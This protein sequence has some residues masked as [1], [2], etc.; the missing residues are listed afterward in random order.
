[1]H[2]GRGLAIAAAGGLGLAAWVGILGSPARQASPPAP[3]DRSFRVRLGVKDQGPRSW[4]GFAA[5][6]GGE[7][8]LRL[9]RP[10][11]GDSVDSRGSFTVSTRS[12]PV[13]V[14]RSWEEERLE[15]ATP[16]IQE[17]GLIVD[18]RRARAVRFNTP[19]GV[20]RVDVEALEPGRPVELLLG[21]V[22]VEL[23]PSAQ[24]MSTG[25]YEDDFATLASGP[26][27]ELWAAWVGYQSQGN[28]ILAR[29]F[30]GQAWEAPQKV[31]EKP[32][33]YFLVKLGRDEKDGLWAVWSAQVNGNW[34]L[35]GRRFDGR[36]WSATARLTQDPQPDIYHVMT[37]DSG[38]RLWLAW[39]GFQGGR[40]DIFVRRL[41]GGSWSAPERVS[42]SAANDWEP[43]LAA[44]KAGRVYVA[45]DTYDKGNYSPVS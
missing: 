17:T 35:Y 37:T 5:A 1:M 29:R 24:L 15:P 45:W 8:D 20:F 22:V 43:A 27:G 9:W 3:A 32:G 39:Q 36:G 44:D 16:V 4:S 23:V 19:Q 31:S 28:E 41:E 34:D 14:R 21:S 13:F 11:P 18:A 26:R 33:D 40:S 7:V 10:R 6:E 25:D 2:S 12:G 30:N 38:G 42:G